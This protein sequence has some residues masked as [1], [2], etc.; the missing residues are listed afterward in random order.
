MIIVQ[1]NNHRGDDIIPTITNNNDKE[2]QRSNTNQFSIL[3]ENTGNTEVL[4]GIDNVINTE[5]R[6]FS[7]TRRRIDTCMNYTRLPLAIKI[8]SY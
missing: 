1:C 7:K 4:Y 3:D 6:F 2:E 8:T 5:L